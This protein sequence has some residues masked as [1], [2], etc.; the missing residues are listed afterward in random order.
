[1]ERV[2]ETGLLK[3]HKRNP[4]EEE[5]LEVVLAPVSDLDTIDVDYDDITVKKVFDEVPSNVTIPD[6]DGYA[7]SIEMVSNQNEELKF[8]C[9]DASI[10]FPVSSER[11]QAALDEMSMRL[12]A[13]LYESQD[14]CQL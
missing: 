5:P 13:R 12:K 3:R 9:A 8:S 1:M 14:T 7:G 4:S 6:G 10:A 11:F 2:A